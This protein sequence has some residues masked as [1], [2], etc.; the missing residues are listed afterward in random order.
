M[1]WELA[2]D[3]MHG[4]LLKYSEAENPPHILEQ[5]TVLFS[6]QFILKMLPDES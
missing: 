6:T 3:L 1:D 2:L 4:Y 5:Q